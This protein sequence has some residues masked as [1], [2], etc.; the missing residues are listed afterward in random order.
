MNRQDFLKLLGFALMSYSGP[1]Q[2]G[3]RR[4]M[5]RDKKRV[6]VIGA[7]LAGLAAAN[8]LQSQG[9]EVL[10]LEARNRVG[11]RIWTSTVWADTPLDFG[12]TWIHGVKG[13][14]LTGVADEMKALRHF[15]SYDRAIT[16]NTQG[17]PFTTAEEHRFEK[18]RTQIFKSLDR[19]QT[20]DDDVSIRHAIDSVTRSFENDLEGQRFADFII[21]SEIEQE[22]AG[23]ATNLSAHWY[24]Q[25][26]ELPGGDALFAQGF[27][28]IPEFLSKGLTVKLEQTV[29]E[30]Q[31]SQS[32][33][34]VISQDVEFQADQVLVTL[35]LGVLQAGKVT[36]TPKLPLDKQNAIAKL[37][38]GVL[39]KCYLR[40][41][42][43]FWPKD[44]DWLEYIPN[45]HGAWTEW[46]SFWRVAKQPILLGFNAA[47]RGTEIENLTDR[48]IV[49]SA[50]QTL[51]TIFGAAIPDPTGWQITRWSK[52]PFA[53]GS[54]SF[55]TVGSTPYMRKSLAASLDDRVFFA[56]EATHSSCFGTAHG[57][58]LSG[59]QAAREMIGS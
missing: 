57:A 47:D 28:V 52:D 50:M 55:N 29:R 12:A 44:V 53:M 6:V 24:D 43:A 19:A 11:G 41:P 35:P 31:W 39:N 13:N 2:A 58:Y 37:G 3:G 42:N 10:V 49:D 40:F 20:Q 8:E 59:L 14:P 27:G 17:K 51:K 34:R 1:A 26:D 5:K 23:S 45:T 38:M 36:F 4:G 25:A 22:Y 33:V 46:V 32:P 18:L 7:G 54:Y 21:S 48:E 9:H 56:G 30:I 15:T 16:Y